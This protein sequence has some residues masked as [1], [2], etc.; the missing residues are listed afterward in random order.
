[1]LS[2]STIQKLKKLE[3]SLEIS[4]VDELETK[5]I[6]DK[7]LEKTVA[8][9]NEGIIDSSERYLILKSLKDIIYEEEQVAKILL[10]NCVSLLNDINKTAKLLEILGN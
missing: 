1:M 9:C 7:A 4:L 5:R 3:D 2:P 8:M 10:G 6:I